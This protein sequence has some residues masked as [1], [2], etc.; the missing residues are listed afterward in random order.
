MPRESANAVAAA[1]SQREG[2]HNP[3]S[4]SDWAEAG[5]W[6]VPLGTQSLRQKLGRGVSVIQILLQ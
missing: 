3:R 5:E 4:A 1:A 6:A 2:R